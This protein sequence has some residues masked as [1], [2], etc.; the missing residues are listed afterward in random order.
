MGVEE[1]KK[2][3][4]KK[5]KEMED[6]DNDDPYGPTGKETRKNRK[7]AG[8]NSWPLREGANPESK[9]NAESEYA[10]ARRERGEGSDINLP[11]DKKK[12]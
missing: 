6:E 1:A 3:L 9:D 12:K 4:E 5:A 10:R 7:N 8:Q 11:A 2:S